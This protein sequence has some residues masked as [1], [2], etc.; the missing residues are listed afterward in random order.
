MNMCSAHHMGWEQ[1]FTVQ[2]PVDGWIQCNS[3]SC[4]LDF[5][6]MKTWP[7]KLWAQITFPLLLH[8]YINLSVHHLCI[9]ISNHHLFKFMCWCKQAFAM[10]HMQT[11]ENSMLDP[12][13]SLY[14]V[15]HRV[16]IFYVKCFYLYIDPQQWEKYLIEQ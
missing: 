15:S 10:V 1:T 11:S 7:I 8:L 5:P 12:V 3:Y 6:I 9:D 2:L 16:M 4:C 14:L 13:L